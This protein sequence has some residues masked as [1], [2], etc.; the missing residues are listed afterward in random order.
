MMI[1]LQVEVEYLVPGLNPPC[2]GM[3]KG[4]FETLRNIYHNFSEADA[5]RIQGHQK[6]DQPRREGH[7]LPEG[8]IYNKLSN[9]EEYKEFIPTCFA[10]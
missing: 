8:S 1:L 2:P 5:R 3:D 10:E 7:Q 6:R 4:I 9:S